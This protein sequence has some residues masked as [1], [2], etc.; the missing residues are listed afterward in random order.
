MK[1]AVGAAWQLAG[2]RLLPGMAGSPRRINRLPVNDRN[3]VRMKPSSTRPAIER[4]AK[5]RNH[6]EIKYGIIAAGENARAEAMATYEARF[7]GMRRMIERNEAK[8]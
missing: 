2:R 6:R 7:D 5:P 8:L 1:K 4:R 3:A